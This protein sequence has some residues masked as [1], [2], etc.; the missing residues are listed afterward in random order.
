VSNNRP[1]EDAQECPHDALFLAFLERAADL[2]D[3]VANA[4]CKSSGSLMSLPSVP[5][6]PS[7]FYRFSTMW[8]APSFSLGMISP[9]CESALSRFPPLRVITS[10]T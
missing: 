10:R 9:S 4:C 2:I 5:W 7:I 6:P 8:L 1:E 3:R